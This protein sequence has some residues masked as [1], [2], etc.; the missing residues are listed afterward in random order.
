[1]DRMG[2][3]DAHYAL[4]IEGLFLDHEE[5]TTVE[6]FR[7]RDGH[8]MG[9]LEGVLSSSPGLTVERKRTPSRQYELHVVDVDGSLSALPPARSLLH[10]Q[11]EIEVTR[12][13]LMPALGFAVGCREFTGPIQDVDPT[14]RSVRILAYG[15]DAIADGDAISARVW[16]KKVRKTTVIRDLLTDAGFERMRVPN[17]AEPMPTRL[18]LKGGDKDKAKKKRTRLAAGSSRWVLAR[19]VARSMRG[20][21]LY[22]DAY[23]VPV[24]ERS[25]KTPC[26]ELYDFLSDPTED[27]EA[28]FKNYWHLAGKKKGKKKKKVQI[29]AH[30][31]LPD[32]HA[33]SA[34]TLRFNGK[35]RYEAEFIEDG[36]VGTKAKAQRIVNDKRDRALKIPVR[37]SV[38]CPPIPNLEEGDIVRVHT[39]AGPILVRA[40]SWT[41]PPEGPTTLGA[42]VRRKPGR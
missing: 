12:W 13:K 11:Y 39:E 30:A 35:R 21:S 9:E 14:G 42:V 32:K 8:P 5:W 38:E 19:K 2:L 1:M 41:S 23:G 22:V 40:D 17:L 33:R 37:I 4:Y 6:V 25:P 15:R 29:K 31:S 7:V 3:N 16:R 36:K 18:A 28:E 24:L 27:V 34:Y 26:L 20:R 10:K